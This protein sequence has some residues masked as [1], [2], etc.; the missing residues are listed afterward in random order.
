M[1]FRVKLI[2]VSVSK[3]SIRTELTITHILITIIMHII[4]VAFMF[5]V[6]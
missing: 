2:V 4:V 1:L 5:V 3:Y 6:K